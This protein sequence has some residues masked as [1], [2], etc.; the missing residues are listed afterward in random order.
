MNINKFFTKC[1]ESGVEPSELSLSQ[2][3]SFSYQIFRGEINSYSLSTSGSISAR[4]IYNGKLGFCK[5]EKDDKNTIDFLLNSIKSSAQAIERKEEPI[6]FKGSE[7]YKKRNVYSKA[8]E[9]WDNADKIQL[10]YKLEKACKEK[11][12]L[13]SDVEVYYEE[14]TSK[15][16]L[17]NSYGLSL[18]SKSN[19]YFIGCN[20]YVND[21]K[22][23]KTFFELKLDND[24]SKIDI[25]DLATKAVNGAISLLG[26]ESPKTGTTK[27]VMNDDSVASLLSALLS[28]FSAEE[29]Q[30]H[31]SALEGKLGQKVFSQ[32]LTVSSEPLRKNIF[33]KY[34]DDEGVATKNLKVIDKGVVTNFFYN[35]ETAKK[36]GVE[37]T[38]NGSSSGSK[39]GISFGNICVKPGKLSEEQLFEKI[40]NGLYIIGLQGLHAGLNPKSG[41]FSLQAQ[42]FFVK[43]GKK[44]GPLGLFTVTGNLFT[45]FN[46]IIA[47]GNNNKLLTNSFDVPSIAFK[48]LKIAA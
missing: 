33:Y 45:L 12:P 24:P 1:K 17:C 41:D 46:N 22:E 6:I 5:T 11:S 27:V 18:P 16:T 25:E 32:K 7:K 38:G 26:G 15:F 48:G 30:K 36:D 34:F 10:G 29:I 47:V 21:G 40:N 39:M 42:G 23:V 8:L 31:T 43:D 44:A 13:V 14:S 35:L 19:Y 4:G 20:V 37:S 9:A 3:T 28:N 2:S